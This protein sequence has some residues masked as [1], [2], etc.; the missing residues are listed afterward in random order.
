MTKK[1]NI[2]DAEE[3]GT[4]VPVVEN[5]ITAEKG[6]PANEEIPEPPKKRGRP[7]G[8]K[9]SSGDAPKKSQARMAQDTVEL[10][11]QI[12]GLHKLASMIS[13]FPELEISDTEGAMLANGI[14]S[15][16]QEYGLSLNGKTGA[17]IQLLGAAGVIYIPRAFAIQ[18]RINE[19]AK[20]RGEV[21]DT[22]MR[23]VDPNQEN[24]HATNPTF[25]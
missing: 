19:E 5:N 3:M 4:T 8:S 22:E 1:S 10:G 17:A 25:N 2:P 11:R 9:N 14:N 16:C 21:V 12:V 24:N 15:V 18:K 13:G 6:V 7:K 23:E 20:K